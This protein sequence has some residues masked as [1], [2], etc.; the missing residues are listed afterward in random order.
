MLIQLQHRYTVSHH[1]EQNTET[2]KHQKWTSK[3]LENNYSL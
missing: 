2:T 1:T 3:K